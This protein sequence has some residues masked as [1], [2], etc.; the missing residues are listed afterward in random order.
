MVG[1]DTYVDGVR[2]GSSSSDY[3]QTFGEE[4]YVRSAIASGGSYSPVSRNFCGRGSGVLEKRR[5]QLYSEWRRTESAFLGKL[6]LAY[7]LRCGANNVL[8]R[9]SCCTLE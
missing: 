2:L 8:A 4:F 3:G 7:E 5:G 9:D 1:H 6:T